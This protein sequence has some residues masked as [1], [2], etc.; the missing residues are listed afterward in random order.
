MTDHIHQ[1]ANNTGVSTECEDCIF[2]SLKREK[3]ENN[4]SFFFFKNITILLPIVHTRK[5]SVKN[6]KSNFTKTK[7]WQWRLGQ[8]TKKCIFRSPRAK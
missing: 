8:Q 3:D 7:V 4:V 6:S 2:H 1:E 5:M